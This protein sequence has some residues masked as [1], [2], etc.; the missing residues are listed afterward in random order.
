[1]RFYVPVTGIAHT[2]RTIDTNA[3]PTNSSGWFF[4]N[5]T[6]ATSTTCGQSDLPQHFCT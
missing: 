1:M 4:T 5:A 6:L 3:I 2:W